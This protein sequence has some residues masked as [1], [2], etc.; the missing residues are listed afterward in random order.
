MHNR[1]RAARW[2][3]L[4]TMPLLMLLPAHA[5]CVA[6]PT[7][8]LQPATGPFMVGQPV[9]V[10]V[11]M[12]DLGVQPAAGFQAF[13]EFD[14]AELAFV[15][16]A[17]TGTPFGLH[18][19]APIQDT[20]GAIDLASGIH[21]LLGQPPTAADSTLA[22]L[23][24]V[25]V[26]AGCR[27]DSVRFRSH[28]PPSRLTTLGGASIEPLQLIDSL[29]GSCA[30]DIAPTT[31]GNGVVNVEDLL[32]LIGSWGACAPTG[33]CCPGDVVPDGQVNVQDLL[34]LI[35][36]WGACPNRNSH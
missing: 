27:V 13:I 36:A 35:G 6:G 1:T 23:T 10:M 28:V 21:A 29:A 24:F 31:L 32:T 33:S 30:A 4:L 12:V 11:R 26:S 25:S 19:I 14:P 7:L 20:D 8:S 22:V 17:Y 16:G 2:L 9:P 3:R 15:S 18:L 5:V 34:G